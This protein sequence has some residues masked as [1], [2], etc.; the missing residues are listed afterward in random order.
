MSKEVLG[1]YLNDHLAG[2]IMAVEMME[3]AIEEDRGTQ[4]RAFLS[5]LV[6]EVKA[7]QELVRGLLEQLGAKE[8]PIKK[9]GAWLAEKAGR[10]KMGDTGE[11]ALGRLEMLETLSL[12]IYGKLKLWLALERAAPRHSEL[13]G[14][15]YKKLQASAREQH[16]RIEAQRVEAALE[17][18]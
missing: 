16:D 12:G 17:A 11:G 3:R 18:F 8:N 7:D 10:L 4:L 13:A 15:D 5:G 14:L 9:A 2:S 6:N 1:T